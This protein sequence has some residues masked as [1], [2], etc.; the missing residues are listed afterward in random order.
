MVFKPYYFTICK[1]SVKLSE[2]GGCEVEK[3]HHIFRQFFDKIVTLSN[4]Q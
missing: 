2:Y 4:F 1:C 3:L